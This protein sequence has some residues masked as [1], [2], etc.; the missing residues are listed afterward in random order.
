MTTTA[1]EAPALSKLS[2]STRGT[3]SGV[4]WLPSELPSTALVVTVETA[5]VL[6][7]L[8]VGV[9]DVVGDDDVD[10]VE[11]IVVDVVDD[12]VV[13][14]VVV[15]VVEGGV[16]GLLVVLACTV[17]VMVAETFLPLFLEPPQTYSSTSHLQTPV[18]STVAIKEIPHCLSSYF[19]WNDIF[20]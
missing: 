14:V 19:P 2:E 18:S 4:F 15:V 9:V 20:S 16:R 11:E 8:V 3:A 10:F 1:V 13:D 17:T 5:A 12:D 7:A 6:L